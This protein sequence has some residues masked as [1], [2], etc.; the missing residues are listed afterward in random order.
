MWIGWRCLSPL[1]FFGLTQEYKLQLHESIFNLI[2]HGMGGWNWRDVYTMPV[3]LRNY[4]I[5]K[6]EK[7]VKEKNEAM[8]P[9]TSQ[10][11]MGPHV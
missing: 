11:S 10:N 1:S 9:S 3:H 6:L 2:T 5:G 4:Y 7:F 8:T